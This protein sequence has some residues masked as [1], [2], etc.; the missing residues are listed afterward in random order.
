MKFDLS[1][2]RDRAFRD[3]HRERDRQDAKFPNQ[4]LPSGTGGS[5]AQAMYGHLL[6][7]MRDINDRH[8]E[9]H[10]ATWESVLAEEVFEALVEE[11]PTKLRAELVQVAA[12]AI[13]W[14]ENIDG[15]LA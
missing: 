4:V 10:E 2:A 9:T 14:I 13:R 8:S 1:K 15:G 7:I 5:W 6:G 3:V 12:V 11:D